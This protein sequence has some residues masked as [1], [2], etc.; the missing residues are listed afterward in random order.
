[1]DPHAS[2]VGDIDGPA[3]WSLVQRT[4]WTVAV[5]ARG[6]LGTNGPQV[7]LPDNE[8]FL[9]AQ[10][11]TMLSC[12]FFTV[13][14]VLFKRIDVLYFVQ[15]ATRGGPGARLHAGP[16]TPDPGRS[17]QRVFAGSVAE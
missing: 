11:H 5:V 6:V 16:S 4:L 15:I 10:A 2:G 13:D 7:P 8:Q 17:D 1:M 9:T 12:D 14:T 3:W